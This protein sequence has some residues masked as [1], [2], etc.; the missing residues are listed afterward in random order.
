MTHLCRSLPLKRSRA[1]LGTFA[2]TADTEAQL[3][4]LGGVLP[5]LLSVLE[6]LNWAARQMHP[7]DV[8]ALAEALAGIGPPFVDAAERFDSV[9]FPSQSAALKGCIVEAAACARR[10]LEALA[11]AAKDGELA[12]VYRVLGQRT[13]AMAALYPAAAALP[14]VSRFFLDRERR[15]DEGLMAV[16]VAMARKAKAVLKVAGA[17]VTY[18]K[19]KDLSHAWPQEENPRIL[20]WLDAT[21]QPMG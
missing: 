8:P 17:A 2:V 15:G 4:A 6:G 11:A 9:A 16:P 5:A 18:R 7:P 1:A 19:I 20:D 13:R 10:A 21:P 14:P 3:R 12:T